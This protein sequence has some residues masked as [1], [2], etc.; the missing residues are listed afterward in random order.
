MADAEY[1]SQ[2]GVK[3]RNL[4]VSNAWEMCRFEILM[5]SGYVKFMH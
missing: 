5:V 4:G 3:S 2:N 1:V